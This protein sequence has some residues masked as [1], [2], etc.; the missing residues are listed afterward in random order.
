MARKEIAGLPIGS[1]V[2]AAIFNVSG[3]VHLVSPGSFLWLMPP[4]LP[5]PIELILISGVAELIAA[6]LIVTK[7]RFA[8][9]AAVAVLFAV[10]PAN[11][12]FAIDALNVIGSSPEITLLAWLRIPLQLPLLWWAWKTPTKQGS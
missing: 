11:W 9:I 2:L 3:V 7:N 5:F 6:F 10:W 1:W 4:F 8:P 12:W